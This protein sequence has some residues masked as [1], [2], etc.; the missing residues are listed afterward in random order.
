MASTVL[1]KSGK[2]ERVAVY[3]PKETIL[4]MAAKIE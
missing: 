4:K 2:N 3:V 1:L